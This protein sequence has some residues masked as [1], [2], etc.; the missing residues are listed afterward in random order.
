MLDH[1]NSP[2]L[3]RVDDAYASAASRKPA[4]Y[5]LRLVP[6]FL[7]FAAVLFVPSS[8]CS[9]DQEEAKGVPAEPT[10]AQE[11]RAQIAAVEKLQHTLP[12][13]GAALYYLAVS[14]Q[15]LRQT[16]EDWRY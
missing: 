12:D 5:S 7:C 6:M 4:S 11:V 8:A 9:Q 14:K 10:D 16:R 13:R 3:G 2:V 1:A 15:H